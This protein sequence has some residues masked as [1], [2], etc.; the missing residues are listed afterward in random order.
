MYLM[1]PPAILA[2]AAVLQNED[3]F[4]VKQGLIQP[5]DTMVSNLYQLVAKNE[6]ASGKKIMK[7]NAG[8]D[9]G[10]YGNTALADRSF[11]QK[12]ISA[13]KA[14]KNS[15]SKYP[16]KDFTMKVATEQDRMLIQYKNAY[17]ISADGTTNEKNACMRLLWTILGANAEM[18]YRGD[19]HEPFPINKKAFIDFFESNSKMTA[20]KDM[21]LNK[22]PCFIVGRGQKALRSF[23]IQLENSFQGVKTQE[24]VKAY[25]QNCSSQQETQ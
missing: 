23:G 17:A 3:C 6:T 14:D 25:C 11:F 21:V 19:D 7:N 8:V 18:I 5:D 9:Y 4:D 20:F 13:T 22:E 1:V 10:L 2:P 12:L 24:A 15:I 16:L